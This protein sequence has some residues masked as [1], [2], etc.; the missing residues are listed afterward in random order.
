MT[1][2]GQ[3]AHTKPLTLKKDDFLIH[4]GDKST[5]MYYLVK[6][7][8]GVYKRKGDGLTQIGNVLEG[9]IVGEMSFLDEAPRSASVKALVDCELVEIPH[10]KF[11][12]FFKTLPVWYQALIHTLLDRLRRANARIRV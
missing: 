6:G 10:E 12:A 7:T 11:D 4:E 8:L 9:E 2:S 3:D 1:T 5:Q